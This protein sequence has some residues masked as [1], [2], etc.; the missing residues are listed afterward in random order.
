[1]A[2]WNAGDL[3]EKHLAV[4]GTP[5]FS[6]NTDA[7]EIDTLARVPKFSVEEIAHHH[8]AAKASS[9][10]LRYVSVKFAQNNTRAIS[11]PSSNRFHRGIRR[12]C[13]PSFGVRRRIACAGDTTRPKN[14][15]S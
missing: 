11:H 12:T 10:L 7:D 3:A 14:S 13:R 8:P 4:V 5:I 6:R 1:M 15:C 2:G 9:A